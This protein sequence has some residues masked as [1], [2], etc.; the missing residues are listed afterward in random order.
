M[1]TFVIP[2]W[3][4][5]Q[6]LAV[7]LR[8][9][10]EQVGSTGARIVVV[11]N[12]DDIHTRDV[13]DWATRDWP[14]ITTIEVDGEPDYSDKFREM[15][16]AAPDSEWVWTFGDDDVLMPGALA[17][18][19]EHLRD[20]P[21]ELAFVHVPE[22]RRAG[23]SGQVVAGRLLELCCSIGWIEMTGFI[24]GNIT[25]GSRLAAC[26]QSKN[27][28]LYARSA[29]VQSC[30]LLEELRGDQAQFID[31]PLIDTQD[32]DQTEASQERWKEEQIPVRYFYVADAL[33]SMFAQG[34]LTR[35]LPKKFFRYLSY[36]LWDRH[37]TFF[38]AAWINHGDIWETELTDYI[39]RLA[40][41][42]ED[43]DAAAQIRRKVDVTREM[44]VEHARLKKGLIEVFEEHNRHMYTYEIVQELKAA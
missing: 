21:A 24:T 20:A 34:I 25:R 11:F 42:L 17:F 5:A 26:A 12:E 29:F 14:F 30:V 28:E 8:S 22:R 1:L 9:I 16:A 4:R 18:M 15:M 43:G 7:A 36:H 6:K 27:W 23:A 32:A 40:D 10:A 41:L 2:T 39:K 38:I 37:I 3:K 35:K 31:L 44:I 19:L 33:E 13:L